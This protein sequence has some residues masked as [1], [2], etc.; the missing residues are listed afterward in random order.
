MKGKRCCNE[1]IKK[2]K[3]TKERRKGR[4]SEWIKRGKRKI[5]REEEARKEGRKEML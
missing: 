2:G 3:K 1:G 4:H 5:C